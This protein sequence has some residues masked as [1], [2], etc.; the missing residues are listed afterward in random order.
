MPVASTLALTKDLFKY[1]GEVMAISIIQG[2]PAPNFLS[3][4]IFDVNAKG[5]SKAVYSLEMIDEPNLK[6][7]Y[8]LLNYM[9]LFQPIE[10][11]FSR[12]G[13]GMSL[14]FSMAYCSWPWTNL[15]F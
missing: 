6:E 10:L 4:V 8:V 3:P 5:L 11:G 12:G 14:W 1:A 13:Q 15:S 7:I 2:G 9:Y